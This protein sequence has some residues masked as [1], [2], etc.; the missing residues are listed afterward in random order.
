MKQYVILAVSLLFTVG[1]YSQKKKA[2]GKAPAAKSQ[3]TVL[4][5]ADDLTAELIKN[6][7]QQ[8]FYVFRNEKGT[9]KDTLLV[10]AIDKALPSE[11]KITTFKAKDTPLCCIT[12]T[13]KNITETKTKNE[14]ALSTYSEIWEPATKT[15][16]LSNVQTTTKIK[17]IV[18]LDKGQNASETQERMRREGFEFTLTGEGDVILKNKSQESRMSYNPTDKKYVNS[19][20]ASAAPAKKKR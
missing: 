3:T 2:G 11:C 8:T 9:K 13:E 18:F 7:N 4:A 12:W 16:I 10:K 14:E 5:K 17:E 20:S 6:K 15:Q 19:V 1:M